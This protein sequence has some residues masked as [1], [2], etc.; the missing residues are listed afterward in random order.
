MKSFL[1][2]AWNP[3]SLL[4]LNRTSNFL[5]AWT[6]RTSTWTTNSGIS[7]T[8]TT[9][10]TVQ[11]PGNWWGIFLTSHPKM[12]WQRLPLR[13]MLVQRTK[14]LT[15]CNHKRGDNPHKLPSNFSKTTTWFWETSQGVWW[16]KTRIYS[17]RELHAKSESK[18]LRSMFFMAVASPYARRKYFVRIVFEKPRS[19][20]G[21]VKKI[22]FVYKR[23]IN[24]DCVK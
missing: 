22:D 12:R 14:K 13:R 19:R 9:Q 23:L 24:L 21:L 18:C 7:S 17:E 5:T 8:S 4:W 16:L 10:S 2:K 11:L 15:N 1:G 3:R 20:E 6:L